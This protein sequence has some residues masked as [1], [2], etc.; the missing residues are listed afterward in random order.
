MG[1]LQLRT[2]EIACNLDVAIA[3]LFERFLCGRCSEQLGNPRT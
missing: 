3:E 2:V 1:L